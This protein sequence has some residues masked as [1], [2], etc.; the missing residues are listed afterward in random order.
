[1]SKKLKD[2]RIGKW[3]KEKAPNVLDTVGD[4]LPDKGVLGVVKNLIDKDDKISPEDKAHAL[5]LLKI[6]MEEE[7]EITGRWKADMSSD[8]WMSKNARPLVLLAAVGMLFI[9]MFLDSLNINFEVK[10][11][12]I[13]LYEMMLITTIGAYFGMRSWEKTQSIK[14]S[15]S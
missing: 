2:T 13:S 11:N 14:K 1:M 5:E 8:S 3:L 15:R 6:E 9:F 10:E 4:L 12:W 7:K